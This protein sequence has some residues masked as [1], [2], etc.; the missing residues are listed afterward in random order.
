[1]AIKDMNVQQLEN[2]RDILTNS[3]GKF[4]EG[5]AQRAA[6][7]KLLQIMDKQEDIVNNRNRYNTNTK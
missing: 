5:S 7:D 4:A 2:A 1:M 3:Y 6:I